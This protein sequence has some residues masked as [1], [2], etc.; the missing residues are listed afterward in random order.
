VARLTVDTYVPELR[1]YGGPAAMP[2]VEE[3]FQADSEAVLSIVE[4]LSGDAGMDA[5]W[6]LTVLGA[7]MLLDDLQLS[8]DQRRVLIRG[9]RDSYRNEFRADGA[10]R[11]Q[12]GERYRQE[13]KTLMAL[14]TGVDGAAGSLQPGVDILNRRSSRV[15]PLAAELRGLAEAGELTAP[16]EEIAGSLLHMHANRLLRS[17]QRAQELVIYDFLDRIYMSMAERA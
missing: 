6:R 13:A 17:A 14:L 2:L 3:I 16:I 12:I 1:R 10:L 4:L 8:T 15:R 11:K 7:S 9:M 5:R